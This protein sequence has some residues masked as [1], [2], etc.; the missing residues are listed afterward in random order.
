[1]RYLVGTT[2]GYTKA[3]TKIEAFAVASAIHACH[4]CGSDIQDKA[5]YIDIPALYDNPDRYLNAVCL[6]CAPRVLGW[7]VDNFEAKEYAGE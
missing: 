1:M 2:K 6:Q 4:Q 3:Y 7:V 5:V